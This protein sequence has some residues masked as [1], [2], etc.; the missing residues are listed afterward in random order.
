VSISPSCTHDLFYSCEASFSVDTMDKSDVKMENDKVL[1]KWLEFYDDSEQ[2][3]EERLKCAEL[4]KNEKFFKVIAELEKVVEGATFYFYGTRY[5]KL[6]HEKSHLNIFID[7]GKNTNDSDSGKKKKT[8]NLIRNV[9][10]GERKF[11][12]NDT[13]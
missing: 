1:L 6:G 4:Q 10:R 11:G 2:S 5:M 7:V 3:I 9:F 12:R 8:L 13:C